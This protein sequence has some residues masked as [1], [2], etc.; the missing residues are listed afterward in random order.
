MS[1][2]LVAI[3]SV[4]KDLISSGMSSQVSSG[5]WSGVVSI[6]LSLAAAADDEETCVSGFCSLLL[7][8]SGGWL[9]GC[10]EDMTGV[11]GVWWYEATWTNADARRVSRISASPG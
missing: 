7:L 4:D 1:R 6:A 3:S 9:G 11:E 2:V 5:G 10:A 8:F